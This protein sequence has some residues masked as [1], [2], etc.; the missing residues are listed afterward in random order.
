MVTMM[1]TTMIRMTMLM[2][3][4][5]DVNDDD[6]IDMMTMMMMSDYDDYDDDQ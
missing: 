6:H 1:T 2:I 5:Y 4:V 3:S